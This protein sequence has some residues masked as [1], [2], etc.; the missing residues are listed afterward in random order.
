MHDDNPDQKLKEL[1]PN[2]QTTFSAVVN[3]I[4]NGATIG[5]IPMI[6]ATVWAE[7]G[8]KLGNGA[9]EI[10]PSVKKLSYASTVA[11]VAFG[12]VYGLQE[13]KRIKEY[14]MAIA[15]EVGTLEDRIA[16]LEAR[17]ENKILPAPANNNFNTSNDN[18]APGSKISE[19][20]APERQSIINSQTL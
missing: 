11:G 3:G 6:G 9:R 13:S 10:P 1:A 12:A 2:Q 7:F 15:N 19:A 18:G 17:L 4:L 16:N 5:S 14:R 20:T 8:K